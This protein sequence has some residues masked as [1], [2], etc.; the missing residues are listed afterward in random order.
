MS[1]HDLSQPV[2]SR[3]ADLLARMSLEEKINQMSVRMAAG[4]D[5]A[6]AA[7][8]NNEAQAEAIGKS[9][10]G[11]PLLM[12]RES[13]HGLNTAGVTSFPACIA[14][15]STWDED[16]NYRIGR[17]I[18]AEARAQGVH[19][20]LS[21][22]L[23]ISRDPR[24]GR[25][26]ETLGEDPLLVSRLGVAFI[27]GLQGDDLKDGIIAC[28]KHL[29][30]YGASEGGK[31]NDPISISE[32]DLHETYLPPFEAAVREANAQSVMICFGAL[33]GVPCTLDKRIV[34]D[35]LASWGFSGHVV[36]DCPG[37]AGLLGHRAASNIKDSIAMGINAGID[38]Q[39]YDFIGEVPNQIAGQEKFE[40]ILLELV[41]EG[42]VPEARINQAAARVLRHKFQL[43]LFENAQVD[44]AKAASVAANPAHRALA[45]EAAC[46]GI[47]LLKNDG[48]LLPL[49]LSKLKALAVIGPNADQVQL[50]D[51]SG[52]PAHAVSPLEGI[53]AAAPRLE[54]LHAKG[55][56]ILSPA[57][58]GARFSVRISGSLKVDRE[59]TYI[60]EVKSNDG[61][62]LI[63]DG[64]PI[65]DEWAPGPMR[66]RA[67]EIRLSAGDHPVCVEYFRGTRF[68]STDPIVTARNRNTLQLFW[69]SPTLDLRIIPTDNLTYRGALGTQQHGSGEGLMMECFL[70]PNFETP[71][72]EQSRPIREINFDWGDSSPIL[73]STA[74]AHEQEA[75]AQ[76]VEV[77]RKADTIIICAGETSI[78]G[79]QQVCG[80]HF[81]R[82]DLGLTGSQKQL[83]MEIAA[84]G[85]PVVLV[86]I[87][88]RALAIPEIVEKVPAIL[89]A[90]YPGQEG[91]HAIA[92]V[93]FG[94]V[95]PS[96][97]LPVAIPRS[98]A[99]LPVYHNR[100][101]RMGW[102]IDEKSE[103]LF[104]FGVGMSY[105]TF[106]YSN[107]TITP[108]RGR[109]GAGAGDTFT[110]EAT[111]ANIGKRQGDEI[112]Q[113]YTEPATCSFATPVTRLAGFQRI[114]LKPGEKK[115][116]RFT[117]TQRDLSLLDQNLR[118]RIVPGEHNI[119]LGTD[120]RRRWSLS[121][122]LFIPV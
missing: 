100:R 92:D 48:N 45:R 87:N 47:V 60:L 5:P 46:K 24:W 88:G 62:R 106:Q 81:D 74:E 118:P 14:L 32:R 84:L 6:T 28:P 94:R 80:E 63:I 58:V 65:I 34:T 78:R 121:G 10:H 122:S 20:G 30:G 83:I 26:E 101:P 97:K 114:S 71:M 27:R 12:T 40:E 111:I 96:G 116:V 79:P 77:A 90:W 38:R 9:R 7:R 22:V 98:A 93:L 59:D 103:P 31:D 108:A 112:V 16:L 41:K 120:S 61:V 43:G 109:A 113:L 3:V 69:S 15:A 73:A 29:V 72:P 13:S 68:L 56:E 1:R 18:A 11:V 57:M 66:S 36:D 17:A 4:D 23:D 67:I 119:Y 55:C 37:I 42:I 117:L 54:I 115:T 76:A 82:A 104:P 33:N 25:Q 89:E 70:G 99:Q 50:G 51:Y 8:L 110:V 21:P 2:E 86:L 102:Y 49:D 35:L 95:N 91:G 19:Q 44:P 64:K 39:F 107:L 105:T 52:K 85:K 75:I 53:K